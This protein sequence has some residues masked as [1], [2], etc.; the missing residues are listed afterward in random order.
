MDRRSIN[1]HYGCGYVNL[2]K[3]GGE[4]WNSE[5][6]TSWDPRMGSR[7]GRYKEHHAKRSKH[8]FGLTRLSMIVNS[9]NSRKFEKKWVPLNPNGFRTIYIYDIYIYTQYILSK[10]IMWVVAVYERWELMDSIHSSFGESR[11]ASN[12]SASGAYPLAMSPWFIAKSSI[13]HQ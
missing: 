3:C 8:P 7:C 2:G 6:V 5:L 10:S 12:V 1:L 13:N 11:G 9:Q 4:P